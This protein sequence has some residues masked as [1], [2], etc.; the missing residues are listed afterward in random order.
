MLITERAL[1]LERCLTSQD[2]LLAISRLYCVWFIEPFLNEI[3]LATQS[4]VQFHFA[5][6]PHSRKCPRHPLASKLAL[7][8]SGFPPRCALAK[9]FSKF[10]RIV[11]VSLFSYQGSLCCSLATAHIDY[12]I[13]LSLSTVFLKFFEVF[14]KSSSGEGGI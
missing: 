2:N 9:F 6:A 11:C 7:A 14:Q 8:A 13:S 1:R 4:L 12:H 5:N 10:S 3:E